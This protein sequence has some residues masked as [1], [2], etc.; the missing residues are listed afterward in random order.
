[1]FGL[2]LTVVAAVRSVVVY[3]VVSLY[4]IVTAPPG[5]LIALL[6]RRSNTLYW[7]ARQGVRLGLATV[8]ISYRVTGAQHIQGGRPTV[9]CVNHASNL[10]PPVLYM[11]P[12]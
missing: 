12:T 2:L 6:I 5:I 9:Y 11:V 7:L 1:M 4:V 8:G 10:E 3:V